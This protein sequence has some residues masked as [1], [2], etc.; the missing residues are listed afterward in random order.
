M[1]GNDLTFKLK[2]YLKG[3]STAPSQQQLAHNPSVSGVT[4][5]EIQRK[6]F[7]TVKLF[8][9]GDFSKEETKE[10]KTV[11]TL[12][13]TPTDGFDYDDYSSF[14]RIVRFGKK[15]S[16]SCWT[17]KQARS[18]HSKGGF[19][20]VYVYKYGTNCSTEDYKILTAPKG[21]IS[22]DRG[23]SA[24]LSERE[25]VAALLEIVQKSV[26]CAKHS[27]AWSIWADYI[28]DQKKLT[29][30]EISDLVKLPLPYK[31]CT[32]F[33]LVREKTPME[34]L[35]RG[36]ACF[37]NAIEALDKHLDYVQKQQ[38]ATHFEMKRTLSHYKIFYESVR[39]DT[40]AIT[41]ESDFAFEKVGLV[42]PQEDNDHPQFPTPFK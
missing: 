18:D 33:Q 42:G 41:E 6:I 30:N 39:H 24:T 12:I 34:K 40:S 37:L 22:T 5:E 21:N 10:K 29:G 25:R 4:V 7:D 15:V 2:I 14:V 16:L 20:E 35:E 36:S 19:L 13:P 27:A 8:I 31:I 38:L 11:I 26:W 32:Y 17:D 1:F 28:L 9:V 23:G 3:P